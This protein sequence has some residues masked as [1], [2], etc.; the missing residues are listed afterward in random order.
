MFKNCLFR[1][2]RCTLDAGPV[3]PFFGQGEGYYIR[4]Y[5]YIL[6][7]CSPLI[8]TFLI[9]LICVSVFVLIHRLHSYLSASP[10]ALMLLF[11]YW[12]S[13]CLSV[14]P[15]VCGFS[16]TIYY[17]IEGWPAWKR[18]VISLLQVT[19]AFFIIIC[20]YL[21]FKHKQINWIELTSRLGVWPVGWVCD[22]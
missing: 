2:T 22:Q 7:L 10:S 18:L 17:F 19:F 6:Y 21:C 3:W 13:F 16:E 1:N 14:I 4:S 12:P 11:Y 20:M 8:L 5:Y 9:H 15:D